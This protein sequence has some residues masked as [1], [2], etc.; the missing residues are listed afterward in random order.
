[1]QARQWIRFVSS[2]SSRLALLQSQ[3]REGLVNSF[4]NETHVALFLKNRGLSQASCEA[5]ALGY[6]K[7]RDSIAFPFFD[8]VN[9]DLVHRHKFRG[10]KE[11]TFFASPSGAKSDLCFG[12]PLA[13][14]ASSEIL[15]ICEGEFDAMVVFQETGIPALSLPNGASSK[16]THELMEA[17]LGFE[18]IVLWFDF[19][20]AGAKGCE[21]FMSQVEQIAG[22]SV[23]SRFLLVEKSDSIKGKDAN[24]VLRENGPAA[25]KQLVDSATQCGGH[26]T[27]L[28]GV[29]D[30]KEVLYDSF[31]AE[32][33]LEATSMTSLTS[34]FPTLNRLLHGFR[35]GEITLY[36]SHTGVGKT[37][38]TSQIALDLMIHNESVER[39]WLFTNCAHVQTPHQLAFKQFVGY[40]SNMNEASRVPL[41][42]VDLMQLADQFRAQYA[43]RFAIFNSS[44]TRV[45]EEILKQTSDDA[46]PHHLVIDS[47]DS[48]THPYSETM[49]GIQGQFQA[50]EKAF[51]LLRVLSHRHNIMVSVVLY[52]KKSLGD[53]SLAVDSIMGPSKLSQEADNIVLLQASDE[54]HSEKWLEVKKNRFGG[55]LGAISLG[56]DEDYC[57]FLDRGVRQQESH[58]AAR[59]PPARRLEPSRK[60]QGVLDTM[61]PALASELPFF[62]PLD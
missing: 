56:F 59:K 4:K 8:F 36:S 3:F 38:L 11:K 49:S 30:L 61:D 21:K 62:R 40:K 47:L 19:D 33:P 13:S 51:D 44:L 20:S 35:P 37:T 28:V 22:P 5:Y 58:V 16:L 12:W 48:N 34:G 53:Q 25:V 52:T 50:M 39:T 17:V 45:L 15:C 14:S 2:Q 41:A 29:S 46:R 60:R 6:C 43:T 10:V 26:N 31:K 9:T 57:S 23:Q 1:M 24:D 55:D 32:S 18:Q 27:T 42:N 54:K 7:E